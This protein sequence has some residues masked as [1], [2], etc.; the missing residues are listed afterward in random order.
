MKWHPHVTV[1]TV[2]HHQDRFLLVKE[3]PSG[4]EDV[5][6]QPAGHLEQGE[7]LVQAAIR[8][9]LEETGWHVEPTGLLAL[10]RYHS[11]ANDTTYLRTSF[12]ARPLHRC[13]TA[14]LDPDI[15]STHWLTFEQIMRLEHRLRSPMVLADIQRYR[16]GISYPLELLRDYSVE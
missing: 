9:T 10:S 3:R 6:N 12:M 4:H 13:D 1:A 14:E 15:I 2:V 7:S 11:P 5:Y 8:E 16:S